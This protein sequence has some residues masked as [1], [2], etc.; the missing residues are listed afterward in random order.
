MVFSRSSVNH[1]S[2]WRPSSLLLW[3]LSIFRSAGR[4]LLKTT[5][6]QWFQP[7]GFH[8]TIIYST[9][10]GKPWKLHYLFGRWFEF[11]QTTRPNL[12]QEPRPHSRCAAEDRPPQPYLV[13]YPPNTAPLL[14][15]VENPVQCAYLPENDDQDYQLSVNK[16][17]EKWIVSSPGLGFSKYVT[18][19]I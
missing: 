7:F 17:N 19:L 18:L 14:I 9:P 2:P 13:A 11:P 4:I 16:K 15:D 12:H 5:E 3:R 1:S 6:S 10:S 8:L